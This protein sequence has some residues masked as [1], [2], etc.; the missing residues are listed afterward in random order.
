MTYT[1]I[2]AVGEAV[3]P[4]PKNKKLFKFEMPIL[5]LMKKR[6]V[7]F[8]LAAFLTIILIVSAQTVP[9][10]DFKNVFYF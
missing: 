2:G 9:V 5:A 1:I 6:L 3:Q 7:L 10:D 8:A 4:S